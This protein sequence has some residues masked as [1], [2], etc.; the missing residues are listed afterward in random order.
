MV[1]ISIEYTGS[2]HCSATHGPSKAKVETDAPV[3]NNGKGESFSPTD[4]VATAFGA[5]MATIMGIVA[6]KHQVELKG[7]KIEVI[8]EMSADSPRRISKL[9][10]NFIVPLPKTHPKRELI[11]TA[12]LSCPVHHSIHPEIQRVNFQWQD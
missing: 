1:K 4:L 9:T 3:D 6:Q 12:A 8:K 11:E 7:M 10:T 2:L 5:C